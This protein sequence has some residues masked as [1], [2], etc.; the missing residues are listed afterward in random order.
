LAWSWNPQKKFYEGGLAKMTV[1][2]PIK[3]LLVY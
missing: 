1:E 3:N 2:T